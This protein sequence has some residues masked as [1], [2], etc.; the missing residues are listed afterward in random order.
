MSRDYM[1]RLFPYS[2]WSICLILWG[3]AIHATSGQ[4]HFVEVSAEAG[5]DFHYT[6]GGT[7]QKYFIET[8]G[9]G[10]AFLDYDSDGLLDLYAVNGHD[11]TPNADPEER[12]ALYRNRGNGTFAEV[13]R[14]AGVGDRGYGMGV[15]AADYDNDG[16]VDLYL[17]NYGAD[18]LYRNEG[19]GT[20]A[21]VTVQAGLGNELWG[22]G[23][24]FFD[25]DN[26]GS[27]DLYVA[28]YVEYTLD[29]PRKD[30]TPY[31]VGSFAGEEVAP[32]I[33]AYPS[34]DNF[35]GSPDALY[36][37]EGDGTFA[38][39][40]VQ[41]GV[42]NSEGKGMGLVCGDYD[43]DGDVDLFV[44]NDQTANFLYQN[45]GDGTFADVALIAGVGYSGDG[46]MEASMGADF[47]DYDNDGFL[48][49]VVPNFQREPTS[50]Y[51][52]EGDGL[53]AYE[54]TPS[55]IGRYSLPYVGWSTTFFDYDNDGFLDIFVAN[56]HTLDNVILFDASTS[57]PQRNQLFRNEGQRRFVEISDASGAGL[58]IVKVSRG[59]AFGDYDNDG[60]VDIFVV[61]SVGRA[62]LLRNDGGNEHNWFQVRVVGVESNRDGVGARIELN[63][64]GLRQIREIK[65][66]S[67]LYSQ[68]DLHASFGLGKNESIE[69]LVVRW[70]SGTVDRMSQLA[71]NQRVVI[72]EGRGWVKADGW[73]DS[74]HAP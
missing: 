48:D 11:L 40:T 4:V 72:E 34:P 70:P 13:G 41:A 66:G 62:D 16:D 10:C 37:N 33:R 38:D 12:N 71:V 19:D 22:T 18:A 7:G 59:A 67:G 45:N 30:L 36:H 2:M 21:D 6:H 68:N 35:K 9:P 61:N 31:A 65:S 74:S 64:G 15:T 28:N 43:N 73:N 23:C 26:D 47:G 17:T 42:F 53:F 60:D 56:G 39:V 1:G 69:Q 8:M 51:R 52:N 27:L 14:E 55:G 32:D 20:F 50:L 25:Y 5:I 54:S 58:S 44:A 3:S 49:L 29:A 63:A 24:A 57:Y 46:R